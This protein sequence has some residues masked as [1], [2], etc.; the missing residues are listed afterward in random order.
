[1]A[2][3]GQ[4]L[5]EVKVEMSKVVWPSQKQM[6]IY[7]LVVIGISVFMALFLGALDLG[8]QKVLTNYLLK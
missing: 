2:N 4:C 5:K 7:T 6:V 8:F 3:L 1:M